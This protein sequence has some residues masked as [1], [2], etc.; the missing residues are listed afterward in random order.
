VEIEIR[1]DLVREEPGQRE[2][3]RRVAAALSAAVAEFPRQ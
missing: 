3:A 1:Q 2:W